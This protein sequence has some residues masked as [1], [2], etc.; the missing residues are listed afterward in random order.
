MRA[1][2]D[3]SSAFEERG[4]RLLGISVDSTHALAA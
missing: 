4:V 2:R 3:D 1:I